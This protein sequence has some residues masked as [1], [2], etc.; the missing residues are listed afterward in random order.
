MQF[1]AGNNKNTGLEEAESEYVHGPL[2]QTKMSEVAK[3]NRKEIKRRT[4]EGE[5]AKSVPLTNNTVTMATEEIVRSTHD[6][7]SSG[8]VDTR[9]GRATRLC[10]APHI[11]LTKVMQNSV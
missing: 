6:P 9:V 8:F 5:S 11:E 2:N 10:T 7:Q 4:R 3:T 1:V